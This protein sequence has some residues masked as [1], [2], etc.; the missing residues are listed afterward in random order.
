M[1]ALHMLCPGL[2]LRLNETAHVS[3]TNRRIPLP[4][5]TKDLKNIAKRV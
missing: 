4:L 3:V 5:Q 2:G 1:G